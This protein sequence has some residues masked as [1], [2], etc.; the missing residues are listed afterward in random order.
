[1]DQTMMNQ[2]RNGAVGMGL[3]L[4]PPMA[5]RT[6]RLFYALSRCQV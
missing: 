5:R 2:V 6:A 1:V 4:P 3:Q